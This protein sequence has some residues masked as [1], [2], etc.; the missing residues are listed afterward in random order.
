MSKVWLVTGS[1]S[2]ILRLA[3]RD[4]L[5]AHL[6][7]GSDAVRY[8]A[9]ASGATRPRPSGGAPS[10]FQPTPMRRGPRRHY[11][12]EPSAPRPAKSDAGQPRC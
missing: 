6:L 5:P 7:L 12:S 1:A 8:A 10:A 2:V 9:A 11:D 3:T 4:R